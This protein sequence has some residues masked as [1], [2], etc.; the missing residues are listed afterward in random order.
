MA[1]LMPH[2]MTNCQAHPASATQAG[3]IDRIAG[4]LQVWR[5]RIHDRHSF[6]HVDERELRELGLS[7]WDVEHEIAKPFWRD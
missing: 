6:D 5:T 4:T 2:A 7:R 1:A 3:L